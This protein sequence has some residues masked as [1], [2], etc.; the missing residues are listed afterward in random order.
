MRIK[1]IK[2]KGRIIARLREDLQRYI[3]RAAFAYSE[4]EY[5]VAQ[6]SEAIANYLRVLLYEIENDKI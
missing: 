5:D 6:E 4:T 3:E 1:K 2:S